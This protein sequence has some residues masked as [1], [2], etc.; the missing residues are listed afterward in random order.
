MA[1]M[2]TYDDFV[3]AATNANMLNAFSQEDLSISQRSPEFGLS[4]LKLQ[5]DAAKATTSEQKLLAQEAVNQLRK[6]Y[7]ALPTTT[8]ANSAVTGSSAP[9]TPVTNDGTASS[10]VPQSGM[11]YSYGGENAYQKALQGVT[12]YA[13]YSYDY[14]SDP[15]YG[16]MRDTYLADNQFME[17]KTLSNPAVTGSMVPSYGAAAAGQSANYYAG[18]L[19]DIIPQLEQDAYERYLKDFQLK[20]GQLEAAAADKAFDHQQWK[21]QQE[22]ELAAIQQKYANDTILHQQFQQDAPVLPDLS[23]LGT[24][25]SVVS[26]SDIGATGTAAAGETGAEAAPAEPLVPEY[27]YQNASGYQAALDAVLNNPAFSYAIQNDP[28]YGSLRKSYMREGQRA[29]EDALARASAGSMGIPS[30]YAIRQATDAG[31]AY[32]EQLMNAIPGLQDNAYGRYLSDF[33]QQLDTLGQLSADREL[34]YNQ[35]LQN[36]ELDQ[37]IKQQNFDNALAQYRLTRQMTPEIAAALGIE[38]KAPAF[39]WPGYGSGDSWGAGIDTT[40]NLNGLKGSSWD[41]TLNN[42]KQLVNVG[43]YS[44]AA[45]YMGQVAGEMNQAQ[46]DQA[47]A[48]ISKAYK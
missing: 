13:P 19:N 6:T 35:W 32:N 44:A 10:A 47:Q 9:A 45:N 3:N 21:T 28:Q 12:E 42:L 48:I 2:Y 7:N 25:T 18:K 4:L 14:K 27:N 15:T 36:Y 31:N 26:N 43:N 17:D 1:N 46:Y 41:Y 38:Y 11:G 30:S 33:Q 34:D 22:L 8:A 29:N 5:Q 40:R 23:R 16:Q 20:N 37:K 39:N 24:G